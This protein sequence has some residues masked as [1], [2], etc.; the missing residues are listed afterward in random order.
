MT[1]EANVDRDRLHAIEETAHAAYAAVMS[2]HD[3][4]TEAGREAQ[5]LRTAIASQE[6][7][8]HGARI[9]IRPGDAP[10][11]DGVAGLRADLVIAEG[12]LAR[13]TSQREALSALWND[14]KKLAD[15]CRTFARAQLGAVALGEQ[16]TIIR[17]GIDQ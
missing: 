1:T 16:P 8:L 4:H 3:R 6:R 13:L 7:E 15:R 9:F 14:R 11:V 2:G 12:E 17:K 5:R 10:P